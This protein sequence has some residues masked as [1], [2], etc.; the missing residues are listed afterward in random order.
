M[1]RTTGT[2][3]SWRRYSSNG[4]DIRLYSRGSAVLREP[5]RQPT[6]QREQAYIDRDGPMEV[7]PKP[8]RRAAP[9]RARVTRCFSSV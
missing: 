1:L 4:A 8:P 3:T 9:T 2:C 7:R 5:H 6:E